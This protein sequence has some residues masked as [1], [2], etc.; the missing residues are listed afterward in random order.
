MLEFYRKPLVLDR[1]VHRELRI[2]PP[3][4]CTHARTTI[5][6]PLM[7]SELASAAH[8]YPVVFTD[9][10]EGPRCVALVGIRAGENLHV[11]ADGRWDG[12]YVPAVVRRYPFVLAERGVDEEPLVCIDAACPGFGA[13][14]GE[15]L[16]TETG[17]PARYLA[18]ALNF[19]R[20]FRA[21]AART[22]EAVS[23]Y[24]GLGLLQAMSARFEPVGADPC[25]LDG[26]RVI[27]AERLAALPGSDLEAL[28]RSGALAAAYA[29]LF[30][31]ERFGRL[32][33]RAARPAAAA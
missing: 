16:F 6:L 2:A 9:A 26:F 1:N 18:E 27:D 10:A 25:A 31:L 28:A 8:E 13:V 7:M 3:R 14:D 5:A 19:L 21:E 33:E 23:R 11:G 4:D 32:L 20:A 22:R 12:R 30:S 29:H 17:E 15:P 24:A